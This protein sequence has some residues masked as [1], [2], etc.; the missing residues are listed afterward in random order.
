M[1]T[2]YSFS[3]EFV[4]GPAKGLEFTYLFLENEEDRNSLMQLVSDQLR[5]SQ[6]DYNVKIPINSDGKFVIIGNEL[7]RNSVI[8]IQP[9]TYIDE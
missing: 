5:I 1:Q 8:S 2:K 4:A 7:I 6:E 9:I 3:I